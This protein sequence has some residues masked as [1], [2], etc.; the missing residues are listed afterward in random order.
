MSIHS[1]LLITM[2]VELMIK[3]IGCGGLN[4]YFTS[5]T[6]HGRNF[7]LQ[8]HRFDGS[9]IFAFRY[10]YSSSRYVFLVS[11]M[12]IFINFV[13]CWMLQILFSL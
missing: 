7:G 1:D 12:S 3:K 10:L 5:F 13:F 6:S 9:A 8:L 2:L 11:S 4:F